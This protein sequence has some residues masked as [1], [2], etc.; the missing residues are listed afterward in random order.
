MVFKICTIEELKEGIIYHNKRK[1]LEIFKD[2]S[3]FELL[4]NYPYL[5]ERIEMIKMELQNDKIYNYIFY[6]KSYMPCNFN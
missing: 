2:N 6:V 1:K 3:Y 5:D 4:K